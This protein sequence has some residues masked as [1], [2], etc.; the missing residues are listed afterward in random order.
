M[1]NTYI[2]TAMQTLNTD[3]TKLCV[4]QQHAGHEG[5]K[6]MEDEGIKTP[7]SKIIIENA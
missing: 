7:T 6:S 5:G 1:A 3:V 2:V 4:I